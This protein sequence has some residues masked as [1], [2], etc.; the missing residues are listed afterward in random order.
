MLFFS[1]FKVEFYFRQMY[2]HRQLF[3]ALQTALRQFPAVLITGPRQSGKTTFLREECDDRFAYVTFDD[4][5]NRAFAVNDPRGFLNLYRDQPVILDEIQYATELL[6]YLKMAIDQDRQRMGQWVLTGSQQ[7]AL[8]KNVSESLAGRIALLELLPFSRLEYAPAD[9]PLEE[10]LWRSAYP[11]PA[12]APEKRDLWLR[13]YVQTYVER[14]VRLLHDIRDLRAFELFLGLCAS[15]HGQVF[16]KA[17]L[18]RECGV[19]EPTIKSWGHVLAASYILYFLQPYSRNYGKRLIKTPKLYFIDAALAAWLTR[20]PSA[21]AALAGGMGGLLFEGWVVS[22]AVK[23]F[24][25][26]GRA[27][28]V[29]FWRSHDGLEV[30][31]IIQVSGRF[32]PVEIKLTA[33]PTPRHLEPLNR[34][35]TLAEDDALATGLLVCRVEQS[36]PLPHGHLALPWRQF[37]GWLQKQLSVG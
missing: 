4:P 23:A 24:T 8:M 25:L 19:S 17:A 14:D 29:F 6:P 16:N 2:L 9:E 5:L 35:K 26:R 22:E 7:F 37:P 31:L 3:P 30:D 33:T 32:I 11:E 15:R 28:D 10:Q 21:A 34:F 18:A 27:P 1:S 13:S 36:Q 20:Q 12:L